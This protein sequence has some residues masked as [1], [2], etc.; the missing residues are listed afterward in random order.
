MEGRDGDEAHDFFF[1]L[2]PRLQKGLESVQEMPAIHKPLIEGI[3]ST[4]GKK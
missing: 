2:R 1:L 3:L 4:L